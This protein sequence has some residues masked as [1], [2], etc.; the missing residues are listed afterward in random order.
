MAPAP[1]LPPGKGQRSASGVGAAKLNRGLHVEEQCFHPRVFCFTEGECAVVKESGMQ[2][3]A[4]VLYA[5][6]RY[7]AG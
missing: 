6:L 2:N 1:R 5:G 3:G 7:R 4:S